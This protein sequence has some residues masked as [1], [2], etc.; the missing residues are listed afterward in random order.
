[1]A[2]LKTR[3]SG[4]VNRMQEM[5]E[6]RE[7]FT[8]IPGNLLKDSEEYYQV[9]GKCSRGLRE[10]FEKMQVNVPEEYGECY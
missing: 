4:K 10:M 5:Q 1:M 2:I 3:D 8:R 9:S 7:M 6:M